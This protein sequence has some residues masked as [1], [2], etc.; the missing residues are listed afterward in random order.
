MREQLVHAG[1]RGTEKA[2]A[3]VL[4]I[5]NRA[6][7]AQSQETPRPIVLVDL[8]LARP[9]SFDPSCASETVHPTRIRQSR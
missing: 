2:H 6:D 8:L 3:L 5:E 1:E 7:A 9:I 4:K